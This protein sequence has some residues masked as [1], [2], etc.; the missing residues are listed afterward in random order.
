MYDIMDAMLIMALHASKKPS[1]KEFK[2]EAFKLSKKCTPAV[3]AGF[4][5]VLQVAPNPIDTMYFHVE[6]FLDLLTCSS[7]VSKMGNDCIGLVVHDFQ[8]YPV[9][10]TFS[11]ETLKEQQADA[12][13]LMQNEL[14][15]TTRIV[16]QSL[17]ALNLTKITCR[18][19]L[20]NNRGF[21][22]VL[23]PFNNVGGEVWI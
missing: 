7:E 13:W 15:L 19:L 14:S 1:V 4:M 11:A 16:Q 8:A 18:V 21:S 2:R 6:Q 12:T 3:Q 23:V 20:F 5:A 10:I 9:R 17:K 22:G